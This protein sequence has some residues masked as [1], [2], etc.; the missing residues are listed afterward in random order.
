VW[1]TC[2]EAQISGQCDIPKE[3]LKYWN[4]GNTSLP[5]M[6]LRELERWQSERD[7]QVGA[8]SQ[9]RLCC[10]W[11]Y[12]IHLAVCLTTGPKFLPKRAL[13]IVRSRA[14]SSNESILSFLTVIQ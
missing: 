8:T 6:W 14:F 1:P 2:G 9:A 12:H 3:E 11:L 13:H 10:Q 5:N 4:G 7:Q